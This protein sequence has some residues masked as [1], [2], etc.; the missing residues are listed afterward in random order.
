MSYIVLSTQAKESDEEEE[1]EEGGGW[2]P[3]RSSTC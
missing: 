3:T 1:E 2:T